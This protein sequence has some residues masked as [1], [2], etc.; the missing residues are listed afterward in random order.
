MAPNGT[1]K[2]NKAVG[3]K[4]SGTKRPASGAEVKFSRK[5][6][7][8]KAK[9]NTKDM[10]EQA[11]K[12]EKP[13]AVDP[14]QIFRFMDL[15]GELRNQ[16]Y[17]MAAEWSKICFPHTW[18]K[19]PKK[20]SRRSFHPTSDGDDDD[21]RYPPP[22][23]LP[24]ISLTQTC[25]LIRTEFRPLWLSTH[26]FPLFVLDGYLK[27][28]FPPLRKP[29]PIKVEISSLISHEP[30][31]ALPILAGFSQAFYPTPPTITPEKLRK[32]MISYHDPAG[33]LRLYIT[34]DSLADTDM[35]RLLK[36][37]IRFPNYT[38]T[39]ISSHP[40]NVPD[41]TITTLS[42]LINHSNPTWLRW[43]KRNV[44]KQVRIGCAPVWSAT[45]QVR[46]VVKERYAP[47]WMKLFS[48]EPSPHRSLVEVLGLGEEVLGWKVNFGVDYS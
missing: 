32:R 13:W 45:E 29:G 33:T 1:I 5:R 25:S 35:L 9:A 23:P 15:P 10:P 37:K 46:V 44:V 7:K 43:I 3:S 31:N 14:D 34:K 22:K 12:P 30:V 20:K 16:I 38:I 11:Q 17:E 41:D 8:T 26:R 27:V 21:D 2:N 19:S 18:P 4:S 6:Q 39:P 48:P 36:F 47:R 40:L 42:T 28:F 24:Y